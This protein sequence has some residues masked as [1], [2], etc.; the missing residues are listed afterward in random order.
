MTNSRWVPP[1]VSDTKKPVEFKQELLNRLLKPTAA[2]NQGK[3]VKPEIRNSKIPFIS[4]EGT[5]SADNSSIQSH[6]V[7]TVSE[8]LLKPTA[9]NEH[10]KFVKVEE[11][12]CEDYFKIIFKKENDEMKKV[13]AVVC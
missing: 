9:N 12:K 1:K 2:A 6:K 11:P 7:S 13:R 4:E 8:R 10:S 5:N 3:Y